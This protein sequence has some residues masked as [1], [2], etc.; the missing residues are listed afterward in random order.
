MMIIQEVFDKNQNYYCHNLY[1]QKNVEMNKKNMLYY[2]RIAISEGDQISNTS[3][4][5]E[6]DISYYWYF[7]KDLSFNRMFLMNVMVY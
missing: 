6:C 7:L 3:K 4:S 1:S 2:D 5:N